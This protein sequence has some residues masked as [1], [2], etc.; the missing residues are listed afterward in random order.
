MTAPQGE[1]E[2]APYPAPSARQDVDYHKA[3]IATL[4]QS[5]NAELAKSRQHDVEMLANHGVNAEAAALWH[6]YDGLRQLEAQIPVNPNFG[7]GYMGNNFAND[8]KANIQANIPDQNLQRTGVERALEVIDLGVIEKTNLAPGEKAQAVFEVFDNLRRAAANPNAFLGNIGNDN[9]VLLMK[10]SLLQNDSN[11]G[12]AL[13]NEFISRLSAL[14]TATSIDDPSVPLRAKL[15]FV[16]NA[17]ANLDALT[18]DS[19]YLQRLASAIGGSTKDDI[20]NHLA[21][22][23]QQLNQKIAAKKQPLGQQPPSPQQPPSQQPPSQQPPGLP[24]PPSQPP[25]SP[26]APGTPEARQAS[27]QAAIELVEQFRGNVSA[28]IAVLGL[29]KAMAEWNVFGFKEDLRKYGGGALAVLAVVALS[30]GVGAALW[31]TPGWAVLAGLGAG[32]VSTVTGIG[33]VKGHNWYHRTWNGATPL[34]QRREAA[35]KSVQGPLQQAMEGLGK[36]AKYLTDAQVQDIL[37][38]STQLA[39]RPG[40]RSSPGSIQP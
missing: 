36:S 4:P 21:W 7:S 18:A 31:A 1:V 34:E 3:R 29:N 33:G 19:T 11:C 13:R 22:A 35:L 2:L 9:L 14:Q 17:I 10:N 30:L 27:V 15:R 32:A 38:F 24:Q 5:P 39:Q 37:A 16:E 25:G 23:K 28:E 26:P 40:Q 12:P 8:Y 20:Q 6:R